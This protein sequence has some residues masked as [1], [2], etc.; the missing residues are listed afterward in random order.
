MILALLAVLGLGW[1]HDS[2]RVHLLS[3]TADGMAYVA[4]LVLLLFGTTVFTLAY[5]LTVILTR[6]RYVHR[7]VV[8]YT[9]LVLGLLVSIFTVVNFANLWFVE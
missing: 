9:A 6:R 8:H 7:G 1:L 3:G 2:G 4:V 5:L